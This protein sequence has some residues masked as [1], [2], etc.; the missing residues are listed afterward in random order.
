VNYATS[1]G[2]ATAPADYIAA[3][4]TLTFAPGETS[5]SLTITTVNEVANEGNKTF[6]LTLSSPTNASLGT[7]N[8]SVLTIPEDK[9]P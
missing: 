8:S 9:T 2:T 6:T 4:G 5:K 7:L 1:N 3:S